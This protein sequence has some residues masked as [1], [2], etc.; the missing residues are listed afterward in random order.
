MKKNAPFKIA[1]SGASETGHCGVDALEQAKALG[2]EIAQHDAILVTGAIPGF[3]M[4]SAMGAQDAGGTVIGFSPAASEKE[5]IET[6]RLRLDH[7]DMPIFTGFGY[8]GRDLLMVRSCDA[9]LFGCGKIGTIHEFTVAYEEGKVIGVLQGD[10]QT[11]K[12]LKRIAD[13]AHKQEKD[14][15]FDTDPRRLVEQ[16][17]KRIKTQRSASASPN[18]AE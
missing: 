9:V 1:I 5:H 2:Q 16:V 3:P 11:D 4:W 13:E 17:L 6:Y 8:A 12:L 7:I 15:I 10:W 18:F 14:I